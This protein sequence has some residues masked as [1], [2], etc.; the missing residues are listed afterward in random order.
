[1]RQMTPFRAEFDDRNFVSIGD[2]YEPS[3]DW[4]PVPAI[5]GSR[6]V[7]NDDYYY[8]YNADYGYAYRIDRNN[9][10]IVALLPA[11][12]G[13]GIGDPWP[14]DLCT[15]ATVPLG[16]RDYYYDTPDYYYRNDGYGIYQVD[17]GSAADHG[18]GV[19]GSGPELRR[20][21]DASGELQRLQCAARLSRHHYARQDDSWYRYGDGFIYEVEPY[22]SPGRGAL[23]ALF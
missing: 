1:M 7:D 2:R 18:P 8:R 11:V 3:Y 9:N 14:Q 23:S 21:P 4:S 20:R 10:L 19:A 17:A 13:Y 6:Y 5:Y 16:Y 12:G 15:A 22:Q